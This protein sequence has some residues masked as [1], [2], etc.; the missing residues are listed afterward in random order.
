MLGKSAPYNEPDLL[1]R[2]RQ[3]DKRTF[4]KLYFNYSKPLYWKL[5]KMVRIEE[6]ADDLLQDLFIRIWDRREQIDPTQPFKVYLY[7]IATHMVYDHY[8]R[9][10]RK[11]VMQQYIKSDSSE[12]SLETE[13]SLALRQSQSLIQ[14]AI[15]Q[16]P[17]QRKQAFI[18]CRMEGK[19]H[20]QA[21]E[22]M[23]IS[24]NTVH[25][26]LTKAT[27]YVKRYVTV[28]ESLPLLLLVI[29]SL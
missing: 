14:A 27:E 23:Q 5:L 28:A 13:Q 26:H 3:G 8:R 10:G 9:E 17:P 16:L 6:V 18:L 25:N 19:S 4:E 24:P 1:L 20:Q 2:L 7:R 15:E 22:I 12:I 11:A 29:S 21:A